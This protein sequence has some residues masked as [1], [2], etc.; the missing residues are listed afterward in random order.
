MK[1][2][3]NAYKSPWGPFFRRS[4]CEQAGSHIRWNFWSRAYDECH[5]LRS[6]FLSGISLSHQNPPAQ[7][8]SLDKIFSR[9]LEEETE[10]AVE[11]RLSSVIELQ[12]FQPLMLCSEV[13]L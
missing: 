4:I 6:V 3:R 1:N 12:N 9:H 13:R 10:G 5:K 11:D 8:I 2:E 7:D